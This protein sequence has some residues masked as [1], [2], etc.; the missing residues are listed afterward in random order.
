LRLEK[1]RE[2]AGLRLKG[3]WTSL[4]R[5]FSE[6]I[7]FHNMCEEHIDALLDVVEAAKSVLFVSSQSNLMRLDETIEKLEAVQ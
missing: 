2:I 5:S 6:D 4:D 7:N 1:L 3:K